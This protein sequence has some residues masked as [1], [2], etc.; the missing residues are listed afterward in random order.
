MRCPKC[1]ALVP[2]TA[3]LFWNTLR[4]FEC[5]KCGAQLQATYLS[6]LILMG[7]SFVPALFVAQSLRAMGTGRLI[8]FFASLVTFLA[9]YL[10]GAGFVPRLKVQPVRSGA[11]G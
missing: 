2:R 5:G 3:V 9:V 8:G 1:E 4:G 6:R 7:A 10:V 11:L